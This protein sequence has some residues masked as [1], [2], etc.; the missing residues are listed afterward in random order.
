MR[1]GVVE[2]VGE[3]A[4]QPAL[5]GHVVTFAIQMFVDDVGVVTAEP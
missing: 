5:A 4:V 3:P 1:G 2:H